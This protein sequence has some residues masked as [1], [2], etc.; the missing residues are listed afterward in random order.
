MAAHGALEK[1][2]D[3]DICRVGDEAELTFEDV[4]AVED[5]QQDEVPKAIAIPKDHDIRVWVSTAV[6][7]ETMVDVMRSSHLFN[8]VTMLAY[9]TL[10]QTLAETLQLVEDVGKVL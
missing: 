6:K 1:K 4:T 5:S 8:D 10:A 2:K 7:I 3:A 9:E